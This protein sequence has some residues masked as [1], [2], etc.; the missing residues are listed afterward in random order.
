MEVLRLGGGQLLR[1]QGEWA[2]WP[3]DQAVRLRPTLTEDTVR[4]LLP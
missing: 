4:E 3:L 1:V 2:Q